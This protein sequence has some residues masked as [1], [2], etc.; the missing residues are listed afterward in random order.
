MCVLTLPKNLENNETE[1][2][3]LVTPTPWPWSGLWKI[4]EFPQLSEVAF[5]KCLNSHNWMKWHLENVPIP[6]TEWS[7][8]WKMFQFPQLSE[9]AFG[10]C[11]NSHNWVKWPLENVPIPTTEWSG[12]R[13]MFQFPQ[14]TTWRPFTHLSSAMTLL[15][16]LHII[17]RK[18]AK[19]NVQQKAK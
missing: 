7:G 16:S 8:L 19:L 1:E 12:L 10:K 13:K 17:V 3:A 18:W 6:T 4:F 11:S 15:M 5:R 14:L 2:I 9:V